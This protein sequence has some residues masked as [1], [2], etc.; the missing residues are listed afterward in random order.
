MLNLPSIR[1]TTER[2]VSRLTTSLT[3]TGAT[4]SDWRTSLPLLAGAGVTLRELRVS[5]APTL[6]A[7]LTTQEVARFVSPPPT[8]VEG[9]ERF[10]RWTHREQAEGRYICF[11][12]VPAGCNHA[13]GLIQVRAL[14]AQFGIGECGFAIGSQFWGTGVFVTAAR[15]VLDFVF[16]AL[17]TYR[18]E[19]RAVIQ[20]GRG[21]GA[22][23][24]L[25]ASHEATLR[26]SF[27]RYG[28]QFDQML[29]SILRQDWLLGSATP[30]RRSH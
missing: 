25:G 18:L 27:V 19:A 4:Q 2:S 15:L 12:I 8:T 11:G 3:A 24:K 5:D 1:T 26:K 6:L 14:D 28:V 13:V 30:G 9:F 7:L 21:N 17:P 22:L 23:R 10:I 20:N 29:W 16:T